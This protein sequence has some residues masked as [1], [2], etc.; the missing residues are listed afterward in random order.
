MLREWKAGMAHE[1]SSRIGPAIHES[2]VTL[3]RNVETGRYSEPAGRPLDRHGGRQMRL[4]LQKTLVSKK[5]T[6]RQCGAFASPD[7]FRGKKEQ[8]EHFLQRGGAVFR[9]DN[10]DH[11]AHSAEAALPGGVCDGARATRTSET[12]AI[13]STASGM[14]DHNAQTTAKIG[15]IRITKHLL[16]NRGLAGSTCV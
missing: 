15:P 8:I 4:D 9:G 10:V 6:P 1:N 2:R 5:R 11:F 3:R 7:A 14:P 16:R 12:I 13:H